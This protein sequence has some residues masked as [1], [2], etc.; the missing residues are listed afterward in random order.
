MDITEESI[1]GAELC[2]GEMFT[3][4]S[5]KDFS[6]RPESVEEWWKNFQKFVHAFKTKLFSHRVFF[7]YQGLHWKGHSL[8]SFVCNL[9]ELQIGWQKLQLL[10]LIP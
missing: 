8:K 10:M 4:T 6:V 7:S 2:L 9:L 5:F 1:S 3:S